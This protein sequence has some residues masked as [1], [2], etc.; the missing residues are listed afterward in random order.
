MIYFKGVIDM[1]KTK[2]GI[3]GLISNNFDNFIITQLMVNN[4]YL[5][6]CLMN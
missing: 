2:W 4:I 5:I 3:N 6:K 1:L